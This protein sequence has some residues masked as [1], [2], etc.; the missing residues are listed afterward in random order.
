VIAAAVK[1]RVR[2]LIGGMMFVTLA[3]VVRVAFPFY[4]AW[5]WLKERSRRAC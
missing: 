2:W 1:R 4:C 3:I 5:M